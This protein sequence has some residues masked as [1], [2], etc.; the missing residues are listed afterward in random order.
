[1][2]QKGYDQ[3]YNI[4]FYANKKGE[5]PVKEYIDS[6]QEKADTDKNS[7]VKLKKIYAY[8]GILEENGTR[9]GSNFI[10][11]LDDDIWELRPLNDRILFFYW[12][13]D[14]FVLLHHFRK[15]TKKTPRREI[16]QAIRNKNDFLERSRS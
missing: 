12:D 9:A 13:H 6:L 8:L 5:R 4:V 1:M 11:H 14:T 7:R 2:H 15:K 16:D 10:K 3:L